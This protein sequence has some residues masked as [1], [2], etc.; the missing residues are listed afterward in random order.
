MGVAWNG[1]IEE[2]G[3]E[4]RGGESGREGGRGGF[5]RTTERGGDRL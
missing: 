2:V 4:R 1:G 3:R 5:G